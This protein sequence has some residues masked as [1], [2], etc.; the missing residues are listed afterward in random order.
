MDR[1]GARP[2]PTTQDMPLVDR[3]PEAVQK[4][5][6]SESGD[7]RRSVPPGM[8]SLVGQ[9]EAR[10]MENASA[11]RDDP[12]ETL[13]HTT[14][15][16]DKSVKESESVRRR[17][18]ESVRKTGKDKSSDNTPQSAKNGN[19]TDAVYQPTAPNCKNPR[20]TSKSKWNNE[21]DSVVVVYAVSLVVP[22]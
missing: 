7:S 13:G 9:S 8:V 4:H 19:P 12:T 18:C 20:I 15:I 16:T 3:A 21:G 6:S 17:D 22:V 10:R 2:P 14:H 1:R 5:M 11:S